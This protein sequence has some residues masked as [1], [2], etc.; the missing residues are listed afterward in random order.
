[1]ADKNSKVAKNVAGG[2]YVDTN[3]I[4]CGQ[5]GATAPD[6]FKED[7][8]SSM[9]YVYQQPSTQEGIKNCHESKDGCPVDAIGDNG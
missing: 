2:F 3:C 6:Y 5:C 9:F 4:C 1:M 8:E 7:S